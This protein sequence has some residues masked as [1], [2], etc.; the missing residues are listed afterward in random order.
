MF[1]VIG[2]SHVTIIYNGN[3]ILTIMLFVVSSIFTFVGYYIRG[4]V[5][6]DN[7]KLL[8]V[9]FLRLIIF[10]LTSFGVVIFIG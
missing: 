5:A 7:F 2:I 1:S 6:S 3:M 10:M 8:K 4:D 9:L